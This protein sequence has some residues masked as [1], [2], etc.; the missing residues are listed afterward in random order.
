VDEW[1]NAD[2]RAGGLAV[3]R[4]GVVPS[5]PL[6]GLGVS[7]GWTATRYAWDMSDVSAVASCESGG[8]GNAI[9]PDGQNWGLMQLNVVH[10]ARAARL[11]FTWEQMLDAR[12]NLLV[13]YDLWLDQ[14]W[15]P[16]ACRYVLEVIQP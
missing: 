7:G 9:S 11:G 6:L 10:K 13:A 5:P 14:G 15:T 4:N 16:W 1:R 2:V 8:L 12:A 3:A